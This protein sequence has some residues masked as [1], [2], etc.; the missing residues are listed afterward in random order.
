MPVTAC[1]PVRV[2]AGASGMCPTQRVDRQVDV[3]VRAVIGSAENGLSKRSG[4][5][6]VVLGHDLN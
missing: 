5:S 6:M 3:L 1:Q 2:S 4:R